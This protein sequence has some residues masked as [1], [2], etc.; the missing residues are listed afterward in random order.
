MSAVH[1]AG[2][3]R[4]RRPEH[5][6]LGVPQQVLHGAVGLAAAVARALTPVVSGA[7]VPPLPAV[8]V[9]HHGRPAD[10]VEE[11]DAGAEPVPQHAP[12]VVGAAAVHDRARPVVA[13]DARDL[14]H[15]QVERLVPADA[16]VAGGAAVLRVALAVR[17]EVHALHRVQ[18]PVGRVDEALPGERVRVDRGLAR[19]REPVAARLDRPRLGVVLVELDGRDA[20]D[21]PV[22][23]VDEDGPAVGVAGEPAHAVALVHAGLEPGGEHHLQG[24]GEPDREVVG[25]LDAHLEVLERVDELEVVAAGPHDAAGDLGRVERHGEVRRRVQPGAGADLAALDHV[26]ATPGAAREADLRHEVALAEA[27]RERGVPARRRAQRHLEAGERGGELRLGGGLLRLHRR[28]LRLP[29]GTL[30]AS[31]RARLLLLAGHRLPPL[32]QGRSR[33]HGR[34][35]LW[36]SYSTQRYATATPVTG[37]PHAALGEEVRDG[38]SDGRA[39][40]RLSRAA[41]VRGEEAGRPT[42]GTDGRPDVSQGKHLRDVCSGPG[43]LGQA[44]WCGAVPR[45]VCSQYSSGCSSPWVGTSVACEL[46]TTIRS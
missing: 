1:A 22:T 44:P 10:H 4:V 13:L 30:H 31:P 28:L 7:P 8:R 33:S 14:A 9:V 41:A 37:Q 40:P 20:Q 15:D 46:F 42:R 29:G 35:V 25:A 45:P 38:R 36:N 24:L 23:H 34:S 27:R 16:L 18:Q 11:A 43:G 5:D 2:G 19:R 12:G 26:G 3:L 39:R 17:V 6:H 21:A 32:A